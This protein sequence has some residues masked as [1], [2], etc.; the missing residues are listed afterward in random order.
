MQRRNGG[1]LAGGLT[2]IGVAVSAVA[3]PAPD[4]AP[5]KAATADAFAQ[6]R[7]ATEL[8]RAGEAAK[9]PLLLLAAARLRARAGASDDPRIAEWSAR[10]TALGG[11]DPRIASQVA[12]LSA[13]ATKGRAAGPRVRTARIV[14]GGAHSFVE[15][16]KAGQPAVIYIEGDG[17]TD[18]TLTVG[19]AC[20][21]QT[22]GDVKICAWTPVRSEQVRVEIGNRGRIDNRVIL[23]TN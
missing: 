2:M 16:F 17:D 21:D 11:D 9:D 15:T 7:L 18:L 12:D 23:G 20:R 6:M 3:A 19:S 4:T 5:A 1:M 10:A 22:P 8:A 14:G 13:E